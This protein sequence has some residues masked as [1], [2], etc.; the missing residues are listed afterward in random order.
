MEPVHV[1]QRRSSCV[2]RPEPSRLSS[3]LL[4]CACSG[5]CVVLALRRNYTCTRHLNL[6]AVRQRFNRG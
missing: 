1:D 4:E 2:S 5:R 6:N 3:Q